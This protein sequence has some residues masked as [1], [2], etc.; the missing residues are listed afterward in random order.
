M[1]AG[2]AMRSVRR[3]LHCTPR[4]SVHCVT[5][6]KI[7]K[8]RR[9]SME[10]LAKL[11]E[12]AAKYA[13]AAFATT[14]L[15]LFVPDRLATQL[16]LEQFRNSYRGY[17]WLLLFFTAALVAGT[18]ARSSLELLWRYAMCPMKKLILPVKD[19]KTGIK[20][21]RMRYHRVQFRYRN[22]SSREGFQEVDSNGN[23]VRYLD[24]DG[25]RLVPEQPHEC[26]LLNSGAFHFPKWG[27]ID[28]RDVFS[29][30][31]DSGCWGISER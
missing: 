24:L 25:R 23:V 9:S 22:G 5:W 26:S 27:E 18:Q 12:L 20:Q 31:K 29:G 17:L 3:P 4:S 8:V 30:D 14:A 10:S 7:D 21:S 11:F 28:W 1:D 15:L 2:A 16:A 6:F 13:W 19:F